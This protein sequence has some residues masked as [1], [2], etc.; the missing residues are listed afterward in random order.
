[1]W[2]WGKERI[3]ILIYRSNNIVVRRAV[4]RN[5]GC[6]SIDLACGNNSGNGMVGSTVYNSHHVSFQN[7]LHVDNV[8]GAGG[9]AG[10]VDIQTAW[11]DNFFFPFGANEWLG[12]LSMNSQLGGMYPEVDDIANM[13]SFHPL[14]TYKNTVIVGG[15]GVSAQ[16]NGSATTQKDIV[17]DGLTVLGG[18]GSD[19]MRVAPEYLSTV[20]ATNYL[21][22]ILVTGPARFG[23]NSPIQPSYVSVSGSFT[24]GAYQQSTC[25]T[26]CFSADP[27]ANG[28]LKYITRIE[29][30]SPLKG[31]GAGGA[32]IGANIVYQYG[33]SG[34]FYGDAGYNTLTT[35]TLWPWPNE[36]RIKTEMCGATTRG[37]CATG[38]RLDGVNA[39]TLT[40]YIWEALGNSIP[41]G[42]GGIY[43]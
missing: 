4:V 28:S 1:V 26:G 23:I 9:R 2:V 16:T 15:N 17:V 21:R 13:T 29:P 40:S 19:A 3:G 18:G 30:A 14:F 10:G 33:V 32:D 42:P 43:P 5:D 34:M 22:N 39:S 24:Q 38:K 7:V 12:N 36:D 8:L 41:T 6:D 37:F 35:T 27:K 25:V 20:T 11:H 31:A